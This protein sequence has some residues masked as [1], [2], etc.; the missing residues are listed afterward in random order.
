MRTG[1]FHDTVTKTFADRLKAA[2]RLKFDTAKAFADAL[3]VEENRYRHW[4][5]GTAQPDLTMVTRM[6]RLLDVEPND[7]M[8]LAV[9]RRRR[10]SSSSLLPIAS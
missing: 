7:L 3:G 4:E 8:P 5:R 1:K 10:P 2:R 9:K 6:C